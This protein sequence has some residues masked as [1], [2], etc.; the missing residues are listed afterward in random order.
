MGAVESGKIFVIYFFLSARA[1]LY[2]ILDL[3]FPE[4]DG[5]FSNPWFFPSRPN[6]DSIDPRLARLPPRRLR[7]A[8]RGSSPPTATSTPDCLSFN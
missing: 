8:T 4:P 1:C 2:G 5:S 3:V 6:V 7:V